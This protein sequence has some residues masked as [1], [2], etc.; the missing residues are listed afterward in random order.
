MSYHRLPCVRDEIREPISIS[1]NPGVGSITSMLAIDA[2]RFPCGA[3]VKEKEV[4]EWSEL[5]GFEIED[6]AGNRYITLVPEFKTTYLG[7]SDEY[8]MSLFRLYF[9]I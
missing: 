3:L 4:K 7:F 5:T 9:K 2:F 6:R 1:L 8:E